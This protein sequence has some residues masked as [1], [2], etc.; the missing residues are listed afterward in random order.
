[1]GETQT[2]LDV[3]AALASD[4]PSS[5]SIGIA[6]VQFAKRKDYVQFLLPLL[7]DDRNGAR[8]DLSHGPALYLK[9]RDIAAHAI[10][11]I[12]EIDRGSFMNIHASSYTTEELEKL[13]ALAT[14][15]LATLGDR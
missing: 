12:L 14:A 9:V 3:L 1:L 15:K 11:R 10:A 13:R 2:T 5:R 7:D 4:A 6:C 8:F